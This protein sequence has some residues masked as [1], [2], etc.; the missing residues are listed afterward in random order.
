M[1]TRYFRI[2]TQNDPITSEQVMT[3]LGNTYTSAIGSFDNVLEVN[4][5]EG[6][7]AVAEMMQMNSG[8]QQP[9]IPIQFIH[10]DGEL[11][12]VLSGVDWFIS[13]GVKDIEQIGAVLYVR[14]K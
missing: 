5:I 6:N 7:P 3:A 12:P 13:C 9:A 4:H 10:Y 11:K 2:E 14:G 1:Y 8:K